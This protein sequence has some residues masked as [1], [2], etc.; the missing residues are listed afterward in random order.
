MP[1]EPV[2]VT[3]YQ[4]RSSCDQLKTVSS[5]A[6]DLQLVEVRGCPKCPDRHPRKRRGFPGQPLTGKDLRQG[7]EWKAVRRGYHSLG[8]DLIPRGNKR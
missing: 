3:S 5:V 8:K 4:E 1:T 7:S 6:E 2:A